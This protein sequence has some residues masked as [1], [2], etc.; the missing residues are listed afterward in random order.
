MSPRITNTISRFASVKI[1]WPSGQVTPPAQPDYL[2][3]FRLQRADIYSYADLTQKLV[4]QPSPRDQLAIIANG[5]VIS[6]PD[7]V[8]GVFI[9]HPY[10]MTAPH[11]GIFQLG[12]WPTRAQAQEFLYKLEQH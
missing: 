3:S 2:L 10:I 11:S 9:L 1:T 5:V 4:N 7:I 12:P 6:H 8:N